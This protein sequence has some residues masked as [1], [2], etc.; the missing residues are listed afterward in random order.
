MK[1]ETLELLPGVNNLPD[2]VFWDMDVLIYL[3]AKVN[4]FSALLHMGQ[5]DRF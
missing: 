1:Y 4:I 2:N 5:R 3:I